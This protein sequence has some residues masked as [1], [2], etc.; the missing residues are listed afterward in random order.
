MKNLYLNLKGFL[1]LVTGLL[2][3][4]IDCKEQMLLT[5][6]APEAVKKDK[7]SVNEQLNEAVNKHYIS[8]VEKLIVEEGADVDHGEGHAV[9]VAVEDGN[10]PLLKVLTQKLPQDKRANVRTNPKPVHAAA[11]LGH[12]RM[13]RFLLEDL[14]E[15]ERSDINSF[16]EAEL[17]DVKKAGHQEVYDY[18]L[19][20]LAHACLQSKNIKK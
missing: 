6:H 15:N 16:T 11:K 20:K 5:A 19:K 9:Q 17:D 3:N 12:F 14:P 18:L 2:C 13:L 1:V 10:F 4:P 7:L 8:V